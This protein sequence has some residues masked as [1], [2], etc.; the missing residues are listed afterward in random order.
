MLVACTSI[1]NRG[2]TSTLRHRGNGSAAQAR[3]YTIARCGGLNHWAREGCSLP[4]GIDGS[5]SLRAGSRCARGSQQTYKSLI[6]RG[7]VPVRRVPTWMKA[8]L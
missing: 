7:R 2:G 8:L 6:R 3:N 1:D 5:E 4:D